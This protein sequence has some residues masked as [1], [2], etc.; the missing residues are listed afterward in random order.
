MGPVAESRRR[1][2]DGRPSWPVLLLTLAAISSSLLL[3]VSLSQLLTLRAEVDT[4]RSEVARR[5]EEGRP[6]QHAAQVSQDR[7]S[8][9]WSGK[10][11]F[12][13]SLSGLAAARKPNISGQ[14]VKGHPGA[15]HALT[16]LRR[17]KRLAAGTETSGK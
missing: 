5:R 9:K 15:Q 14:E 2:G 16:L 8:R 10:N 6:A 3:A 13:K 4:L 11:G 17:Q 12:P 1:A 7:A